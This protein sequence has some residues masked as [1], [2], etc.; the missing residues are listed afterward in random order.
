MKFLPGRF[1]RSEIEGVLSVS[2][3]LTASGDRIAFLSRLFLGIPYRASTLSGSIAENEQLII[4]LESVDCFT[5]LDYVEALR[6]A[7]NFDEFTGYL[8]RTRYRD[9]I[10]S[11]VRRNHFF[12]DWPLYNAVYIRDVTGALGDTASRRVQKVLN[13]KQ[14]GSLFIQGI[15]PVMRE[16]AFIPPVLLSS[17]VSEMLLTGD[18]AGIYS[19]IPGLDVSHVGFIIRE[20][21]D[22]LFRHA[23][24]R[25]GEVVD[26][27]FRNYISQKPGVIILRPQ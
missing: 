17:R 4:D 10:V 20:G 7:T 22:I 25:R 2:S 15:S 12:T 26:E 24:V 9:G 6:R 19:D 11:F 5:L 16:I 23:S 14:D 21:A 13:R 18:Y 8:I 3:K 1:S 27:D